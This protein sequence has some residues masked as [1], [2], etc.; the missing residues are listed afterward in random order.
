MG[1]KDNLR[2][3]QLR[4]QQQVLCA[5]RIVQLGYKMN[6]SGPGSD[7]AHDL[8]DYDVGV[9]SSLDRVGWTPAA[10]AALFHVANS[11]NARSHSFFSLSLD[12]L[13]SASACSVSS[14]SMLHFAMLSSSFFLSCVMKATVRDR[15]DPLFF[16]HPGTIRASSLIPSLIVSLRRRSTASRQRGLGSAETAMS[17]TNLPCDYTCATSATRWTRQAVCWTQTC[18]HHLGSGE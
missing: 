4:R 13:S 10:W 2:K 11:P 14:F 16:S 6:R 3:P 5:A 1:K 17:A 8:G 7:S 15:M 12:A 18:G 9:V